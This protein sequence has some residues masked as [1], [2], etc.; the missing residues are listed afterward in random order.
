[1]F[2]KRARVAVIGEQDLVFAFRALGIKAYS[3]QNLDE[4]RE[5]LFGLE[6]QISLSVFCTRAILMLS[7]KRGKLWGKSSCPWSWDF[8]ITEKSPITWRT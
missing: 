7:K 1:M 5:I 6:K 2:D 3:P 8:P 4:A